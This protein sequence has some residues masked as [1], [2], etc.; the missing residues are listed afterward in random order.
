MN[1]LAW[2]VWATG[3]AVALINAKGG[4]MIGAI[5]GVVVITALT[6]REAGLFTRTLEAGLVIAAVIIAVRTGFYILVGFPDSSPVLVNL[7]RVDLAWFT[8]LHIL[9]PIHTLGL[10]HAATEG[11]RLGGLVVVFAAATSLANPRQALRHLPSSLHHVGTAAVIAVTSAPHLVSSIARV[12]KARQLRPPTTDREWL[13]TPVLADALDHCLSLAGSMD[14]RG[15]ARATRST[16][17]VGAALV[18]ALLAGAAGTYGLLTPGGNGWGLLIGG[19]ALALGASIVASRS[20]QR[21]R[22]RPLTWGWRDVVTTTTGIAVGVGAIVGVNLWP[23]A[24][25]P[26]ATALGRAG[27][28][29]AAQAATGSGE[30]V[31]M[32]ERDVV[33]VKAE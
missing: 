20:V 26:V 11:L 12:R 19:G 10:I 31:G 27:E 21:T 33:E 30:R 22:Y 1:P 32:E 28:L 6:C 8:N 5:I 15:Y 7:P 3:V 9:G 13:I 17:W 25:I 2:W 29:E 14:S 16:R 24:L 4:L 23:A 18:V